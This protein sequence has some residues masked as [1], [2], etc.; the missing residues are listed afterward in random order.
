MKESVTDTTTQE[1]GTS[2]VR[3]WSDADWTDRVVV[4]VIDVEF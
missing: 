3:V 1:P 4:V 2:P